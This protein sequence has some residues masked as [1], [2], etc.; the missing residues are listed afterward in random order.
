M[1]S[2]TTAQKRRRKGLSAAGLAAAATL[3]AALLITTALHRL[4]S[5]GSSPPQIIAAGHLHIPAALVDYASANTTLFIVIYHPG[6]PMP[7]AVMQ[8]ALNIVP[9]LATRSL[10]YQRYFA[11][12]PEKLSSMAPMQQLTALLENTSTELQIKV[13]LDRDGAGGRDQPGD[14]VSSRIT[15]KP[16]SEDL[17]IAVDQKVPTPGAGAST[18]EK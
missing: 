16:Y 4:L 15:F 5:G 7:L 18:V 1:P 2:I 8:E 17:H 3:L 14:V 12:T 13:R 11:I 6:T 9:S 10:G